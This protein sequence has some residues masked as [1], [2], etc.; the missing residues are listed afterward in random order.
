[1]VQIQA[2]GLVQAVRKINLS[3]EDSGRIAKLYVIEGDRVTKGQIIARMSDE[4]VQA[5]VNQ[6]LASLEKAVADLELKRS[7]TRPE[8]IA[9][10]QARVATAEASVAA[11]QARLNR[12][13]EEFKRNQIPAQE[14]AISQNAFGEFVAKQREAKAN[15]ETELARLKEQQE[16]LKE[17]A[18]YG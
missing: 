2:N 9:E 16:S 11:A 6:N 12:A 8:E 4:K 13:T 18:L 17:V 3:P 15:L 5:Q 1:M 14:G 7:G 10:A